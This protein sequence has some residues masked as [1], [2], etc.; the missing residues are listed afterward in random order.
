MNAGLIERWNSV[1]KPQ[2]TVYHLG[3]FGMETGPDSLHSVFDSLNGHKHLVTGNHDS[4]NTQ[5]LKLGWVSVSQIRKVKW[6]GMK[7]IACHFPI[8]SWEGA[9][10]GYIHVHGHSHGTLKRVIPHRFDVGA[11]VY[12]APVQFETLWQLAQSQEFQP[13]DHHGDL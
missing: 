12:P 13:S 10:R 8:E 5:V 4:R 6:E 7:A 9:H 1:V 11:D 3:D 2:D